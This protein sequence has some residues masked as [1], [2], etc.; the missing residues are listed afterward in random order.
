MTTMKAGSKIN[1]KDWGAGPVI[2]FSNG[3]PL[4]A[5]AWDT[6][7]FYFGFHGYRVIAPDRRG[8]G[9]SDQT[10]DGNDMDKVAAGSSTGH[11]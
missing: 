9:R 8:H 3:W 7:M 5:N 10:W 11:S 4:T 6:Q 2:T 1:Y